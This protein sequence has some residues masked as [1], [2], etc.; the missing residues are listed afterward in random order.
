MVTPS[1]LPVFPPYQ[2]VEGMDYAVR[3]VLDG[4]DISNLDNWW[5]PE[6]CPEVALGPMLRFWE[7]EPLDTNIFGVQFRRDVYANAAL[8]REFRGSDHAIRTFNGLLRLRTSYVL[9]PA[10]GIPT[11]IVFTV[12]PPVGRIP[13]SDWQSYLRGA[14]RWL[15][16][17]YL[18]IEDFIVG[19]EFTH[20]HYHVGEF[21]LRHRIK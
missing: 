20:T 11:G 5:D 13:L 6:E 9:T 10:M 14:Y 2:S 19:L 12:S 18:A 16:P 8:F 4:L 17:P 15:L 3:R 1:V 21:K 7:M